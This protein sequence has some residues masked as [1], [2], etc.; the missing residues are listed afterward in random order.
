[1]INLRP[2]DEQVVMGVPDAL[3]RIEAQAGM[4]VAHTGTDDDGNIIL[5]G[6]VAFLWEG[7]G[8]GWV[9]TSELLLK[10]KTWSH[11]TIRDILDVTEKLHDLHRIE[12]IILKGHS[13]SMNW[14]ERLSFK[15][16]GMLSKYDSSKNDYYLYA[17]VK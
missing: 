12:S 14:A 1:M 15:F 2:F 5:I 13:V 8:S 6:G 10:H 4:G 9:L 17:R 16:E 7:V 3:E 11:R